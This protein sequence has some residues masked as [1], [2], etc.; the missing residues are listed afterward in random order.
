MNNK[1]CLILTKST[2]GY[3]FFYSAGILT[4]FILSDILIFLR[5]S[6]PYCSDSCPSIN[7]VVQLESKG[8]DALIVFLCCHRWLIST[9]FNFDRFAF[10]LSFFRSSVF[11]IFID[12]IFLSLTGVFYLSI[13]TAAG[14]S[15][16]LQADD[17]CWYVVYLTYVLPCSRL[18]LLKKNCFKFRFLGFAF[19]LILLKHY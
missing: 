11:L 10:Y 8:S 17:C 19:H 1:D 7:F 6:R 16:L 4:I 18:M 14:V 5:S 2:K 15:T 9:C 3:S 13:I 12:D